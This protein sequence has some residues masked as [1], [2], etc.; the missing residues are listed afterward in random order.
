MRYWLE[1]R[2]A[3]GALRLCRGLRE[4]ARQLPHALSEAFLFP[5]QKN[6]N[7]PYT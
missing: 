4:E 6:R 5:Y 3:F 7:G 2:F 1:A